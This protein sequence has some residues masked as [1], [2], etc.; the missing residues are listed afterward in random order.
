MTSARTVGFWIAM[1]A[2]VVGG[3]LGAIGIL[4]PLLTGAPNAAQT[5]LIKALVSVSLIGFGVVSYVAWP[6]RWN[7]VGHTQLAFGLVAYVLPF[8]F[9][10]VSEQ[11]PSP[12]WL[13]YAQV[14]VAGFPI[15]LLGAVVG[16]YGPG[17][18]ARVSRAVAR[19]IES[20]TAQGRVPARVRTIIAWSLVA[21]AVSFAVMG[22]VP[23]LADDPFAAKFFRG[24]YADSYRPVAPLYRAA[25][26]MIAVLLPLV[27]A[28]A[29]TRRTL[30]WMSLLVLSLL[31]MLL[32]LQRGPALGGVVLFFG[33]L[34]AR[35]AAR[36]PL[37]FAALVGVYVAGS[38]IYTLMGL[39]GLGP[40]AGRVHTAGALTSVAEGAPDVSDHLDFLAHWMARPEFTYGRTFFGGLVPG[41]FEWNPSVWTL[42]VTN[43]GVAIGSINSGGFRLPAPLWGYVSFGWVGVVAV[44][45]LYG[46]IVGSL[47]R[48]ARLLIPGSGLEATVALI[49][50][51]GVVVDLFSRFYT[52]S[53]ISVVEGA[54]VIAVLM[55]AS[56]VRGPDRPGSPPGDAGRRR[57]SSIGGSP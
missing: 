50:A 42:T 46:W 44:C 2:V 47:A 36:M 55:V 13:L 38:A 17:G 40:F 57:M 23:A 1:A 54:A 15:A 22:F 37:Y 11:A 27:A 51:Y 19:S 29:W 24:A 43:P 8:T 21:M 4:S 12:A 56:H 28:Y 25:T 31:T 5:G 39:L 41:N 48:S 34:A 6:S 53:Y 10:N 33:A 3:T 7:L 9:L 52:L 45:F 16:G 14:V 26:S 32:T 18:S 35:R 49:V 30:G 20:L